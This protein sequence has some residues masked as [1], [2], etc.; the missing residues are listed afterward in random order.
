MKFVIN[1]SVKNMMADYLK[2][3]MPAFNFKNRSLP[4]TTLP[5][6]FVTNDGSRER[7]N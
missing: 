3:K 1:N 4:I 5:T 6:M 2:K 7:I